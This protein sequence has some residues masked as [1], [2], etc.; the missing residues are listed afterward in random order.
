MKPIYARNV[1][2]T[3][4]PLAAQAGL[5][6]IAK[7]GNAVDA[8]LAAAITLTVVE[9]TMNGIGGDL[10]AMVWNDGRLVG[11]NAS[12]RAPAAWTRE[13]FGARSSMPERG[14]GSVTVPGAVSAWAELSKRFGLLVFAD[15][16]EAAIRYADQGF[17]VTPVVARQ[18]VDSIGPLS[19]Y[20]GFR[21]AFTVDGRAPAVGEVW[22]FPAQARTLESIAL[23]KG[24]SFYRGELSAAMAAFAHKTGGTLEESDLDAHRCEWVEP[25]AFDYHRHRLYE[26]PPNGQGIAAQMALG[27]LDHLDAASYARLS[28]ERVHLQIEAMRLAFADLH[29]HVA[30]P[31]WM[32]LDPQSLLDPGYLAGRARQVDRNRAGQ[33]SPGQPPSGGTVYLCAA[34][35]KGM[36]VSLIQSNYKGFGSGV[37]APGGIA[38][39]NRGHAF[40]LEHGHPNQVAPGKRPFHTIIPAFLRGENDTAMAFGVMGANMQAQGHVQFT[41]SFVDDR[42]SPQQSSD[43]PRWRINDNGQLIVEAHMPSEVV[44]GLRKLGHEPQ[45][46]PA[47]SLEFG[48]AQAIACLGSLQQG[49]LSG[50]DHRRDGQAVGF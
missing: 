11:L 1:V 47:D 37:V 8:A 44:E 31:S 5:Q 23:S 26:I 24:E 7:G 20:P 16:F 12:G 38:L 6:A 17:P 29:A 43:A 32:R 21:E 42:C 28:A 49:Y 35:A 41:M 27:I 10:F 4:Q 18:W 2:A 33:Y 22:R 3:S 15:L 36:M 34:D 39:H 14:W 13:Y 19:G 45:V 48:S 30:D 9:P 40:S 50:S 25:L 46:M